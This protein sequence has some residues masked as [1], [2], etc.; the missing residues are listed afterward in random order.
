ME[1]PMHQLSGVARVTERCAVSDRRS[2][3]KLLCPAAIFTN[4]AAVWR[5]VSKVT[6]LRCIP[7]VSAVMSRVTVQEHSICCFR[8]VRGDVALRRRVC[9]FA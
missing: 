5:V 3:L 9:S 4:V 8:A 2:Q 7:R 6:T 1:A